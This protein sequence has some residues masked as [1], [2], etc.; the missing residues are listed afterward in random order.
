MRGEER[1]K[2]KKGR[3]GERDRTREEKPT[4]DWSNQVPEWYRARPI[5]TVDHVCGLVPFIDQ[6]PGLRGPARE[7]IGRS[8]SIHPF[9][10]LLSPPPFSRN[11]VCKRRSMADAQRSTNYPRATW[12]LEPARSSHVRRGRPLVP[13]NTRCRAVFL[14][15]GRRTEKLWSDRDDFL[16]QQIRTN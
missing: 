14:E 7:R 3:A 15:G 4:N 9:S 12:N 13:R 16:I 10:P 1:R 6:A 5:G 2:R 11:V 8:L